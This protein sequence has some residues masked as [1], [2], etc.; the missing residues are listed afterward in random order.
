VRR[1]RANWILVTKGVEDKGEIAV[2]GR[3]LVPG[4]TVIVQGQVGLPDRTRVQGRP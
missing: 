1:G 2:T 4:D 3:G